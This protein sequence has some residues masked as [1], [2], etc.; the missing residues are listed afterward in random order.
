MKN[1]FI[2]TN[3]WLS[4][5]HFTKDD[6][7]QFE[8]L[9]DCIGT[10][11]NLFIPRQIYDEII[12]NR[13]NKIKTAMKEFVVKVPAYP[14]FAKGY[15]E[16][17]CFNEDMRD[18]ESRY[19]KW[20]KKIEDDVA[21]EN[22]PADKTIAEFFNE[23]DMIS[24]DEFIDLAYNRYRIGNPPGKDNKYGDAINWE[25]LLK[26]VPNNEDIFIVSA[27]KDYRS[28]IDDKRVN[29]FLEKEWERRKHGKIK[30]YTHLVDFLNEHDI[31][32][33]TEN[34]KQKLIE[35]LKESSSFQSTHGIIAM[36]NKYSGWTEVQIEELC[37][38]AEENSQVSWILKDPD[39]S[40]FYFGILNNSNIDFSSCNFASKVAIELDILKAENDFISK[41]DAEAD[42][43]DTLE[44]REF[45]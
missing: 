20:L 9:K 28:V 17:A 7:S 11:I 1:L 31:V 10:S 19:K 6:L 36:L 2:D 5:Y 32:L 14:A 33:E 25:T 39:I 8:K 15:E 22:L 18:I 3:I 12:R 27:D 26:F 30:F 45:H 42:M 16:F 44:D 35:K 21:N 40:E 41:I 23:E 24:C 13:E 4:L 38:C 37:K 43:S 29:P 34:E